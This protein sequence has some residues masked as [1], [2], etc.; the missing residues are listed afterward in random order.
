[1]PD[2]PGLRGGEPGGNR[3][4]PA[5]HHGCQAGLVRNLGFAR[6]VG[7]AALGFTEIPEERQFTHEDLARSH[8]QNRRGQAILLTF[9]KPLPRRRRPRP[10]WNLL[11]GG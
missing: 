2:A 4:A 11:V 8:F 6:A 5:R 10:R 9:E 7:A 3:F 1:M